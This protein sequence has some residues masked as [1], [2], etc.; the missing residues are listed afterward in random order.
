MSWMLSFVL[1]FLPDVPGVLKADFIETFET[2]IVA[3]GST[4]TTLPSSWTRF[5]GAASSSQIFHPNDSLSFNQFK[6]LASPA[7]GDQLLFL[8][9]TNVGIYRLSGVIIQ[10]NTSY[11]LSAAIGSDKLLANSQY[12]SIQLWADSNHNGQFEGSSADTFIGQQFG[13]NP[14]AVNPIAGEWDRNSFT[15]S[16][17][18]TPSLVGSELVVF[19][20]NFGPSTSYYDNVSLVAVPEPTSLLM[21]SSTA[22]LIYLARR[23]RKKRS[24]RLHGQALV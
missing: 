7:G 4:S 18:N 23:L 17:T 13:T 1:T 20:N 14:G 2:P 9:G 6:S 5:S 11:E 19:L 21:L 12:W 22:T 8:S 24:V 16:S 3:P 15:F 10:Q